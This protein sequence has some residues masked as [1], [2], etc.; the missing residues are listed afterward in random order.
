MSTSLDDLY[1]NDYYAWSRQQAAELRRLLVERVNTPLDLDNLAEE[2]ESLGRS[3]LRRVKSQLRRIIEH[4][5]KLQY[6][7][8][9]DPRDGWRETILE[10]RQDIDD[11]LTPS[12]RPEI[13]AD[14]ERDYAK[15]RDKTVLAL[16]RHGEVEA[17]ADLPVASPYTLPELLD[18]EWWPPVASGHS[19]TE[20]R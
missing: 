15:A 1:R 5:L 11:Y 8:A 20:H 6:S 17:A 13:E 7:P 14:L 12:M 9:S 4:L 3:D 18:P 19:A 16:Q 10:A 2:V